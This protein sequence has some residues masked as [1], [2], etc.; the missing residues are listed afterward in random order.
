[1]SL[2]GGSKGVGE[3]EKGETGEKEGRKKEEVWWHEFG[4]PMGKGEGEK[5][6][7][8]EEEGRRGSV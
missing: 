3:G 7:T 8:D 2:G 6:E 5:G 4:R 1:M